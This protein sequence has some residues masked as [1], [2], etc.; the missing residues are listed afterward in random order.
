MKTKGIA[1]IALIALMINGLASA[2]NSFAQQII[3]KTETNSNARVVD[4]SISLI[5]EFYI[6][7]TTMDLLFY[8]TYSTPD[9][10]WDD[11]VSL[12]FPD[13][14][15]VNSAS[16]CTTTGLQQLPYNGE[17]GNG[18]LVTWGNIEGG[19][20][21]GGLRSSGG[22][23]VN[24]SISE[25]F[26]GPLAVD[27]Y[28]AGDGYGSE[29]NYNSGTIEL[30][31]ALD[32][33]LAIVNFNPT[34][35]LLGTDFVPVVSVKNVGIEETT[36]FK[37]SV[38]VAGFGYNEEMTI[39]E[40]IGSNET[41]D[42]VFP[43]FT[44]ENS[45]EYVAQAT[46]TEGG[47]EDESN[48]MLI[49][50]GVVAPLADAYAI[51]GVTHSY[52]EVNLPTGEMV[53]VG[54][55]NDYPWQ[56]A[57]EYDGNYI[58]RIHHDASIGTV[59]PDGTYN[60]LGFMTGVPGYAG[61]LAYNWDTGIMYVLIQNIDTDHS[62][63]CTLN[64]DTYALTEIGLSDQLIVGM[65][66]ANNGYLYAVTIQ[67]EL[68]KIDVVTAEFN[69][70]GPI[71]IDIV[72]PQDVSYDVQTGLL[73]TI[74]S[75]FTFS[76]FGTY[77]LNTGAFQ[78]I[79]DMYGVY[80]Y[81]LVITKNPN[82]YNLGDPIIEVNPLEISETL[83]TNEESTRTIEIKN[84]GA[85]YLNY[86]TLVQYTAAETMVQQVPEG[87]EIKSGQLSLGKEQVIGNESNPEHK[88]AKSI[89]LSY[90]GDNVNAIGL[91]EGG[92][93]YG[94]T[95]FPSGMTSVYENYQLES[96]DVFIGALPS[97][98][99]LMVWDAGTTTS[100]GSL[101]YEQSFTPTEASWNT[102]ILENPVTISG[103]DIWVGFEITH[104]A[105]VY[106]LGV[107]GGPANSNGGWISLDALEW[108]R[109]ANYGINSNWNIRANLSFN[110]LNWLSISPSSGVL[111]EEQSEEI[112]LSFNSGELEVGTY[113][114]N[115]RISSNDAGN[116]LVIVPVTLEVTVPM[117]TLTLLVNPE[118]AGTVTGS[119]DYDEGTVVTVNATA[120]DGF[121]FVNWTDEGGNE[122]SNVEQNEITFTSDLTLIANFV[123]D[124]VS[125]YDVWENRFRV[126][127]NPAN[128]LLQLSGDVHLQQVSIMDMT[129]QVVYQAKVTGQNV[130]LNLASLSQG[131]YLLRVTSTE[132][133]VYHTRIVISR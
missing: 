55:V 127:P 91:D 98:I 67:N 73:Y 12:D 60:H 126:Y 59:N 29:P 63:L 58:Y 77:D 100:A 22:F 36:F 34:F 81:T 109:L 79:A 13:G 64:M 57:E 120:N 101:M 32:F 23:S 76:A 1:I 11:G 105:N 130:T 19:S 119:G 123:E 30:F 39:S 96:V 132:G 40:P 4:S 104:A 28:I 70:V 80:Y 2:E 33:D 129:G 115:I 16:V 113:T 111:E 84:V 69:V 87:T 82:D 25:D 122:V 133:E 31:K 47:G 112:V 107:D 21:A 24:V 117:H 54:T 26:S 42:I 71:G 95:R 6:P 124:V 114:A 99:K 17:T 46:I 128:D 90:D 74:A 116:S 72:Y 68:L 53:S 18:A 41:V 97:N 50:N 37:V 35:V 43:S 44:P 108:E 86:N 20:G 56:L 125:V 92:T 93:F 38:V 14:V 83:F 45:M 9:F 52:D 65:D 5:T 85:G 8:Y 131:F 110:G 94:A 78:L 27:W 48:D 118:E 10:E 88:S 106:I 62:H 89:T 51:N 75:G 121:V 7:G 103:A 102:V 3:V 49:V 66:F 61:A 15:F